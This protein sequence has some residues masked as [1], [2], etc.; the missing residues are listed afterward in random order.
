MGGAINTALMHD[1]TNPYNTYDKPGLPPG[2][3]SNPGKEALQ[4]AM[5]PAPPNSNVF[6]LAINKAGKAA[7]AATQTQFCQL[8]RQAIA[9]GVS[10]SPC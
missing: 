4:A 2:P 1:P 8:V 5:S 10:A 3:I 6:F 9:N 7:F